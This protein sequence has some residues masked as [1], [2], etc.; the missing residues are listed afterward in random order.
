MKS[1]K[2]VKTC[3]LL[4]VM[5]SILGKGLEFKMV[6]YKGPIVIYI[7]WYKS[8]EGWTLGGSRLVYFFEVNAKVSSF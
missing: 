3:H 8:R 6:S 4:F 7:S 5:V 1:R 2:S